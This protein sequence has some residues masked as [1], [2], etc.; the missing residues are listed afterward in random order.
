MQYKS[1]INTFQKVTVILIVLLIILAFYLNPMHS[2]IISL[3]IGCILIYVILNERYI[4]KSHYLTIIKGFEKYQINIK[5]IQ[6][7]NIVKFNK[8]YYVEIIINEKKIVV[9][10]YETE[11]F[12]HHLIH[13]N[14][15]INIQNFNS[16]IKALTNS[17]ISESLQ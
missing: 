2:G 13:I 12:I 3:P 5:N 1:I 16:E 9:R 4:I 10:P 14:P 11:K 8:V 17:A 15:Q 7:L 6:V